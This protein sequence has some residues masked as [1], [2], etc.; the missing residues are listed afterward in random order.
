M[1]RGEKMGF[2]PFLTNEGLDLIKHVYGIEGGVRVRLR[3]HGKIVSSL[4]EG[5]VAIYA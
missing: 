3:E 1:P 2:R 4:N 5:Y